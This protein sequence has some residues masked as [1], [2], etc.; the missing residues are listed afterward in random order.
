MRSR[1]RPDFFAGR[2]FDTSTIYDSVEENESRPLGIRQISAIQNSLACA[3][4]LY[5]ACL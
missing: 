5:S 1:I 3:A 2:R 4:C